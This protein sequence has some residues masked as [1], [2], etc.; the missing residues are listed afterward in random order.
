M[1]RAGPG[2][3]EWPGGAEIGA[4]LLY[5]S[6]VSTF[7]YRGKSYLYLVNGETGKVAGG[8]PYS[9]PK[10]VAAILAGLAVLTLVILVLTA[11]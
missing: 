11:G 3:A 1:E 8:R 9:I 6:W 10:L 2:L 4:C 7:A 5:T